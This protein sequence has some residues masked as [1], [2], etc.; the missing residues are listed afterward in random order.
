L[1]TSRGK[2]F[3]FLLWGTFA[4]SLYASPVGSVSGTVKDSSGAIVTGVRLTLTNTATNAQLSTVSNPQGEFQFL[5]LAPSTYSLS[6]TA[7]GFKKSNVSSV[8][9]Q[10][11]QVT[12]VDLTLEVGN[13]TE[14][15]Q[16]EEV[17]TLLE[18]D[19][20]TISSVV[21]TRT[22]GN[23]PRNAAVPDLALL[24][25]G[26]VAAQPGQQGGGSSRR[27]VAVE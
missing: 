15:I 16:V 19:K 18:S 17:S 7:M 4:A 2:S 8:L 27:A 13:V 10:V 5:Q 21:D 1:K 24:T 9:V 11:D 23:M 25:P 22:I 12:H 6:A 20:S 26:A 3:S 14:S